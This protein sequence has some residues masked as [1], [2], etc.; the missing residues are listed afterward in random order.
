[1]RRNG[2]LD[3][4]NFTIPAAQRHRGGGRPGSRPSTGVRNGFWQWQGSGMAGLR[5]GWVWRGSGVVGIGGDA[6]RTGT[7]GCAAEMVR[8]TSIILPFQRHSG[9]VWP[10]FGP[11]TIPAAQ[12]QRAP[13]WP[14]LA[15]VRAPQAANPAGRAPTP[16]CC[17]AALCAGCP[18]HPASQPPPPRLL[19]PFGRPRP[20]P[21]LLAGAAGAHDLQ[22]RHDVGGAEEVGAHDAVLGARLGAHLLGWRGWGGVG[23]GGCSWGFGTV[24][25]GL[26]TV[27]TRETQGQKRDQKRGRSAVKRA[28]KRAVKSAVDAR[29]NPTPHQ[30]DVDGGGVG[31]ED[32]V[33][34]A[35]RLEVG[36]DAL[37]QGDVLDMGGLGGVGVLCVWG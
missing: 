5:G 23:L 21:H 37:L 28:V 30:V 27:T 22:Q 16:A 29:S 6:A 13:E 1:V 25:A 3:L 35:R 19:V 18:P 10:G 11:F 20:R 4:I 8:S 9:W 26:A 33:G 15:P 17:A 14:G 24:R 7:G 31:G 36:K 32:G 12:R 2:R 34:A